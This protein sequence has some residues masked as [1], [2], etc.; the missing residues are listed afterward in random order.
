M[1][2]CWVREV[3][4]LL[5]AQVWHIAG[6]LLRLIWALDYNHLVL[7]CMCINEK[8]PWKSLN[9]SGVTTWLWD[10][11]LRAWST[12]H[13]AGGVVKDLTFATM[14]PFFRNKDCCRK[15]RSTTQISKSATRLTS[16]VRRDLYY[17]RLG[18]ET[19]IKGGERGEKQRMQCDWYKRPQEWYNRAKGASLK[20]THANAQTLEMSCKN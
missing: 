12:P 6:R 5:G 19:T 1:T 2:I 3:C 8:V 7:I 16:L 14:G 13:A 4:C 9:G 15:R 18:K 17:E 20:C 10:W 11:G